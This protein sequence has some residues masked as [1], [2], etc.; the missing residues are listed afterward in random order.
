MSLDEFLEIK[1]LIKFGVLFVPLTIYIFWVVETFKW[2][3]LL[4]L[5][6]FI[7]IAIA[8]SGKTLGR[9]HGLGRGR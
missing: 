3:L 4:T 8:L 6:A 9:D 2:K 1:T 5:G 7:G